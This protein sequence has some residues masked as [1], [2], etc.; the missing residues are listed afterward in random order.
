MILLLSLALIYLFGFIVVQ[1][2]KFKLRR[3]MRHTE[4]KA[5]QEQTQY[6]DGQIFYTQNGKQK[7][8]FQQSDGEYV[9][10][11]EVK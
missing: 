9:D 6:A 7:K 11:E 4:N 5:N 1:V 2:I 3:M 8:H 10:Y